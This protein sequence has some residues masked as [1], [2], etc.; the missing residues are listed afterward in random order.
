MTQQKDTAGRVV[1]KFYVISFKRVVLYLLIPAVLAVQ[2]S[3]KKELNETMKPVTKYN[4][5]PAHRANTT[6]APVTTEKTLQFSGYTWV[7]RPST[8][9]AGP[10][11][12][13]W[14]SDNAWVD[15]MGK[16]HLKLTKDPETGVWK[17]AEVYTKNS[18]AIGKYQFQ[19]DGRLDQL[20]KNVVFGLFNYSGNDGYDEMD[21][22]F[23]RWGNDLNPMLNYAVWPKSRSTGSIWTTSKDFTL[24]G[25]YSTHRFTRGKNWVKFQSLHGFQNDDTGEFFASTCTD[26][27]IIS[28]AL[29]PVYINLWLY[30][31]MAPSNNSSVELV[32]NSFTFTR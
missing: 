26:G 22:E 3:C 21:I 28:T 2:V 4:D 14:S 1:R 31:G 18:F 16:L 10:G 32:V 7:V 5:E 17:C 15:A 23:S 8:T 6:S 11:P 20:D 25:N 13:A 19:V 30:R 27:S 24:T 12:N 9:G 29:M